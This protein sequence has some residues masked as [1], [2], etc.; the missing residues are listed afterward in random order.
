MLLL[1]LLR[2][3]LLFWLLL[4]WRLLRRLCRHVAAAAAAAAAVGSVPCCFAWRLS[5]QGNTTANSTTGRAFCGISMCPV[6]AGSI[7]ITS[8]SSCKAL[9]LL[10]LL[11]LLLSCCW[12]QLRHSGGACNLVVRQAARGSDSCFC[13]RRQG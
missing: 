3:L 8:S 12:C 2:L 9:L 1:P 13:C 10:L 11:L 6:Y 5:N 4:F 7:T